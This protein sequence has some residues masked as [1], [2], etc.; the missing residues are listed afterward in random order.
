M[1]NFGKYLE[2]SEI[3]FIFAPLKS[4][5]GTRCRHARWHLLYLPFY[6]INPIGAV[7]A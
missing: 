7:T 3:V 2:V 5:S 6:R 1:L 4:S